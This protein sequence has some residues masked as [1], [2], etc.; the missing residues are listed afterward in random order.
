MSSLAKT[1]TFDRNSRVVSYKATPPITLLITVR[2]WGWG[3][4]LQN[5]SLF[6]AQ[7]PMFDLAVKLREWSRM[8]WYM[9]ITLKLSSCLRRCSYNVVLQ[10]SELANINIYHTWELDKLETFSTYR[11]R[12]LLTLCC[13]C[14]LQH[15]KNNNNKFLPGETLNTRQWFVERPKRQS[16]LY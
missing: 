5:C 13:K 2:N 6:F 11:Y 3:L 1:Q 4:K 9:Y 8:L 7:L 10:W 12:G 14:S 15:K 16:S